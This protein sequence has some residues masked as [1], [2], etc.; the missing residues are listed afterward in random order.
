MFLYQLGLTEKMAFV[1]LAK[2]M[3]T[4][5]DG[6]IDDREC[7]L[8]N[9]MAN[10]MQV[11]VD[12]IL[13]IEFNLEQ[14]AGQFKSEPSKRICLMELL[15]LALVNSEFHEKQKLLLD[16]LTNIFGI[17]TRELANIDTWVREIM[18]CTNRGLALINGIGG[19]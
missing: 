3:V 19:A 4:V 12:S 5:D 14:L 15:S 17:S 11:S 13:S 1:Q 18:E 7:N 10:E 16:G 2:M 6:K 9:V 8:I